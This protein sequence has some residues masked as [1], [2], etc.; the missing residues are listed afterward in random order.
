MHYFLKIRDLDNLLIHPV[1]GF[2]FESYVIE[3]II[4]GFQATMA[5][6]LE[7]SYYRTI[8]KSEVDL[9]V[10]G[11]FGVVPIE[12]KLNSVVKRR[13]LRGLENFLADR[14]TDQIRLTAQIET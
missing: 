3:E 8:D 4:R 12:I 2:T 11:N 1:A 10:E 14:G 6:P 9:V 5:T 13:S 7:F